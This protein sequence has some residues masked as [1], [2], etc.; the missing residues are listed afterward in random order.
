MGL[1]P[2]KILPAAMMSLHNMPAGRP[3]QGTGELFPGDFKALYGP[4]EQH[5]INRRFFPLF[6]IAAANIVLRILIFSDLLQLFQIFAGYID[7]DA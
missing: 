4:I 6:P 1:K 5:F 3:P 2:S 7:F